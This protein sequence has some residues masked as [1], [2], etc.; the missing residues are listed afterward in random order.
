MSG[1]PIRRSLAAFIALILLG[2]MPSRVRCDSEQPIPEEA[3]CL[4]NFSRFIEWP[5]AAFQSPDAP[6]VIGVIGKNPFGIDLARLAWRE[7]ARGRALV[8]REFHPGDDLRGCQILFIGA[9][10]EKLVAHILASMNGSSVLTVSDAG[11]FVDRGG[12][13]GFS[14]QGD[15]VRFAVNDV[16]VR[17]AGIK[18][19]ANILRL[20]SEVIESAGIENN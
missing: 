7:S 5:S 12:M 16:A 14:R 8:V 9:A 3:A 18:V 2:A 6:F 10:D 11:G 13:I 17:G 15:R 4:L 1:A 19:S 20:A